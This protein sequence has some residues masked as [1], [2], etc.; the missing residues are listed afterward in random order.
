MKVSLP[1]E[2]EDIFPVLSK[3]IEHLVVYADL[4]FQDWT[5]YLDGCSWFWTVPSCTQCPDP[6]LRTVSH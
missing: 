2:I 3:L 6:D 4:L 5:V 1:Y